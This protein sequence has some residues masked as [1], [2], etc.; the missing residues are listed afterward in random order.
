MAVE[1][2]KVTMTNQ[3]LAGRDSDGALRYHTHEAV[4]F[5]PTDILDAYVEDAKTRWA[6]VDSGDTH[7]PG[8]GG[9][10]GDTHY[11]PQLTGA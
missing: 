10:D 8:P 1:K 3:V 5:V 11:P 4:D 2:R 9:D 6:L 7:D